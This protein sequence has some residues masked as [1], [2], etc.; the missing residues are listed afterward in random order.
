MRQQNSLYSE[1]TLH[2]LLEEYIDNQMSKKASDIDFFRRQLEKLGY[3]PEEVE[4]IIDAFDDEVEKE[5]LKRLQE[6]ATKKRIIYGTTLT[7]VLMIFTV[8][9][10]LGILFKAQVLSYAYFAGIGAS[11]ITVFK[12][13][14]AL[15]DRKRRKVVREILWQGKFPPKLNQ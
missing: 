5:E 12:G 15:K 4:Q 13:Y 1:P 2:F 11:L 9:S 14:D 10:A 8:L 6:G 3:T 7:L